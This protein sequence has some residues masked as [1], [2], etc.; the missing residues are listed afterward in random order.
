VLRTPDRF[1]SRVTGNPGI[2]SIDAISRL[3]SQPEL[4]VKWRCYN[5]DPVQIEVL[6]APVLQVAD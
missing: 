4:L 5:S 3:H 1:L 2:M 6:I